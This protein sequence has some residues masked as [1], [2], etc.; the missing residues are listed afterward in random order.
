MCYRSPMDPPKYRDVHC[1]PP[2]S[3]SEKDHTGRERGQHHEQRVLRLCIE[4]CDQGSP[5]FLT[6]HARLATPEED[7][8]GIDI[9]VPTRLGDIH[10][11]VKSSKRS[12][13]RFRATRSPKIPTVVVTPLTTPDKLRDRVFTAL[14]RAF[15]YRQ[16][17][18]WGPKW[19]DLPATLRD[20]A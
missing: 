2:P 19:Q 8:N 5:D 18:S 1:D 17:E 11:Q 10:L 14:H 13:R 20:D 6:S 16:T 15:M 12:A 7:K 3:G 4:L 9:V